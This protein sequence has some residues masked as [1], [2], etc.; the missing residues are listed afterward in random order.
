MIG[1]RSES[2][3]GL[4]SGL[5]ELDIARTATGV[6]GRAESA[7]TPGS[8][9]RTVPER[10]ADGHDPDG[11]ERGNRTFDVRALAEDAGLSET[12]A[13]D[14]LLREVV[15][16]AEAGDTVRF[17]DRRFVLRELHAFDVPLIV[18]GKG[19]TLEFGDG[20]GLHFRGSHYNGADPGA[21]ARATGSIEAGE[22]VVPVDRA[23]GFEAGDY[24]L[25]ETGYDGWSDRHPLRA[26]SGY[27][28]LIARVEGVE[29]GA[30][31]LERP[32]RNRFDPEGGDV[33]VHRFEPLEGPV[34]RGLTTVG[35]EVPL[36]MESCVGGRFEGC[37][38]AGYGHY[39]HRIDYCLDAVLEGSALAAWRGRDGDRG[40]AIHVAHSTGTTIGGARVRACRHGIALSNGC[41]GIRIEDPAV[42]GATGGTVVIPGSATVNGL[43]VAGDPEPNGPARAE[44]AAAVPR[45]EA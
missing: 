4:L 11:S 19:S 34:F 43:R 6:L 44:P 22:R 15:R 26:G 14:D 18:E 35:G 41:S 13:C 16:H 28:C 45:R 5:G 8:A 36:R 3:R 25:V 38:S 27:D 17:R 37:T 12:D 31:V 30:L 10:V 20:G 23:D 7:A 33:E 9:D 40:E 24:A 21:T 39:G 42:T 32:A 2:L 29:T 1:H